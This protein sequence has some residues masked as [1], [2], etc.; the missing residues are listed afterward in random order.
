MEKYNSTTQSIVYMFIFMFGIPF[1]VFLAMMCFRIL[2][3][4]KG[5]TNQNRKATTLANKF[6]KGTLSDS[7][8]YRF[9]K[10][11]RD[12]IISLDYFVQNNELQTKAK[13]SNDN[14]KKEFGRRI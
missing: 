6:N 4:D 7:D 13:L 9:N 5:I 8:K 12:G 14:L 2:S 3:T 11:V 1:T 10:Y